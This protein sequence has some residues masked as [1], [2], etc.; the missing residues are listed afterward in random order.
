MANDDE[1]SDPRDDGARGDRNRFQRLGEQLSGLLDPEAA[2]RRGAGLVTGVSQATKE[3]LMRIVGAEVRGFLDKMDIADL[4]QQ[5][6]AGLTVDVHMTVKFSMDEDGK[7]QP[8]IT[9]S[10]ADVRTEGAPSDDARSPSP[11]RARS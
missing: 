6:I 10:E 7:A 2:I 9:R 8:Q 11:A 5:I 1:E 4:A 3:E